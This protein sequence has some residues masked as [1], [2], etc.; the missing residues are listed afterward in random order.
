[1]ALLGQAALAMWWDMAPGMRDEF[2]HW[3]THE[4]FPE[5]LSVPGFLRASRWEDSNG[6]EGFFVMYEVAEFGVLTSA[7]YLAHLNAPT[8][9]STKLMPHHRN[10]VR[11]QCAVGY[12]EGGGIA[13][14]AVTVRLTAGDGIVD[15]MRGLSGRAGITGAH[16]LHA[17]QPALAPTTEQKIRGNRDAVA[18]WIVVL[19]GYE[20]APLREACAREL[21]LPV[22]AVVSALT[23]CASMTSA[24]VRK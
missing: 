20:L 21:A 12:S 19:C 14:H 3:H 4:H 13:A 1:M 17:R 23:L 24:E 22:D 10:M 2:Q 18:E 8:P 7:P 15:R 11:S 9:W 6:D 16:F 5:R